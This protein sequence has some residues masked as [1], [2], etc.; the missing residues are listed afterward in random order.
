ML[1]VRL[2]MQRVRIRMLQKAEKS[3]FFSAFVYIFRLFGA[4]KGDLRMARSFKPG[5]PE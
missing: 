4:Q 3:A 1:N 2:R 5:H